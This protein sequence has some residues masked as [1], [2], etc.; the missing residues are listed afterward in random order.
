M[1]EVRE[2][3]YAKIN[4]ALDVLR[5]RPDGYH[6]VKMIMQSVNIYDEIIIRQEETKGIR[7]HTDSPAVPVNEHNLAWRAAAGVLG[8]Y[9][10][11]AGVSIRLQKRIPVAAGMAGGSSDAAAVIRGIN[12]LL[13]LGLSLAEMEGIGREIGADVPFCL[14]GGTVLA[15]GIGE[16]LTSLVSPPEC[17]LVIIHPEEA[18]STRW[19]YEHLQVGRLDWH[20]DIDGMAAAIAAGDWSGIIGRAGNVLE[21]VTIPQ[22]PVITEIKRQLVEWGAD[23]ALMSGSGPTV[24]GIFS[25][26]GKAEQA[27]GRMRLVRA[28]K[29]V[30]LT[31]FV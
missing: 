13:A 25:D 2:K 31:E 28:E 20:P 15:E 12:R 6:E 22:F 27:Y 14:R 19:V 26:V 11:A 30:F 17:R 1:I 5:R 29:D 9:A 16:R 8:R 4:L 24:L 21:T 10:P 3:A 23:R 18:V 7:L